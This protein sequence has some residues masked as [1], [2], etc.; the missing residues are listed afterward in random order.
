MLNA[1][2]DFVCSACD[3]CKQEKPAQL[4]CTYVIDGVDS[5]SKE[6]SCWCVCNDCLPV[7]A[8]VHQYFEDLNQTPPSV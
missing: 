4:M 3:I 7:I 5:T 2:H 6:L 1:D 8:N